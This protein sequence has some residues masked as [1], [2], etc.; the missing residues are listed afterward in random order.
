MYNSCIV[1]NYS[2]L[3][4]RVEYKHPGKGR[5][6]ETYYNCGKNRDPRKHQSYG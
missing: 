4:I 1:R 5:Y 3:T 6:I 2:S